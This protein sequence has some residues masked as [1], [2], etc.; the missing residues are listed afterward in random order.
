[1]CPDALVRSPP[2]PP[3]LA[4]FALAWL[5]WLP[6]AL[7]RVGS[8]FWLGVASLAGLLMFC[9]DFTGTRRN[10]LHWLHRIGWLGFI[11]CR[12]ASFGFSAG[13]FASWL[14]GSVS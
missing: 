4:S 7:L 11:C 13:S 12:L 14:L 5:A 1:M 3:S 6:W 10:R 8:A 9:K 2:W